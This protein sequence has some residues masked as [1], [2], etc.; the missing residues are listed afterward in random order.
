M[1]GMNRNTGKIILDE[2]E[3]V[4]QS[5]TDI[6]TTP[7]GSR[8][9]R[10]DYGSRLFD[11]IDSPMINSLEFYQATAE[12]IELWEPRFKLEKTSITSAKPGSIMIEL[13]GYMRADGRKMSLELAVRA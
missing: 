5:I 10:R 9:M 3:H 11:L 7:L 6:L 4:R 13:Q 8:V 1:I 2:R 12:A